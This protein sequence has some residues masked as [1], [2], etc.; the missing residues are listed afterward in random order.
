[1]PR[2]KI[3]VYGFDEALQTTR[4]VQTTTPR[5]YETFLNARNSAGP[6][7]VR[8]GKVK[9]ATIAPGDDAKIIDFDGSNDLVTITYDAR[10]L[11]WDSM[12]AFTLE[13]LVNVDSLASTRTIF[14]R[15][16]A[17]ASRRG[18]TIYQDSTSGGRVVCEVRDSAGTLAGT[19]AVT[20]ISTSTNVAWMVTFATPVV[21]L[22]ANGS[23]TSVSIATT[24][25]G[26]GADN[27]LVGQDNGNANKYDGRQEFVRAFSYAKTSQ[28]DNWTRL[29]YPRADGVLFDYVMEIDAGTG[30]VLDRSQYENHADVTGS[31]TTSATLLGA[32][33]VPIQALA[34]MIAKSGNRRLGIVARGLTYLGAY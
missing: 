6:A 8:K 7:K 1:M 34:P 24:Y 14:A 32:P 13:G 26:S 10:A 21:T 9:L 12:P 15:D 31:P 20:G 11:G 19:L 23:S 28:A 16:S 5:G 29:V 25:L 2:E 18:L 22:Y 27:A 4:A 3:P 17:T 30:F 33:P